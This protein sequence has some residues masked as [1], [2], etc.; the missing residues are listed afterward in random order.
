VPPLLKLISLPLY[1]KN[2]A[3]IIV[4]AGFTY[5]VGQMIRTAVGARNNTGRFEFPMR[6]AS[7]VSSC[8]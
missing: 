8:L 3:S 7:L 4:T 1:V 5:A 6:A 2:L